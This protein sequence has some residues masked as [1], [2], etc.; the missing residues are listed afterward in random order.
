MSLPPSIGAQGAPH[1]LD[2]RYLL[3]GM[4]G[5]GGVGTVYQATQTSV[6][7]PVAVK[8]LNAG[9]SHD[10]E[11][12]ARFDLEAKALA[13]LSHPGCVTLFDFGHDQD[14]DAYYMVMEYIKGY[15]FSAAKRFG[16]SAQD[17]LKVLSDVCH[18]LKHAHAHGITHR[19]LKPSNIMIP[20]DKSQSAKVLD[21]GLARLYQETLHG[22][23]LSISGRIY[24]TPA[25]MSPEQCR[26]DLD[27][28]PAADIYALG[29]MLYEVIEGRL[30]F[31]ASSVTAILLMHIQN[32]VQ[33]PQNTRFSYELR[34]L[35]VQ[36]ALKDPTQRFVDLDAIVAMLERERGLLAGA[37]FPHPY[38]LDPLATPPP[39][40]SAHTIPNFPQP[41]TPPPFDLAQTLD[42]TPVETPDA[43][44][45]PRRAR[46]R[47]VGL[48]AAALCATGLLAS[49]AFTTST[50]ATPEALSKEVLV[51]RV[52]EP[53]PFRT[54]AEAQLVHTVPVEPVQATP[55]LLKDEEEQEATARMAKK[56]SD[57]A[58][59]T[60]KMEAPP[61]QKPAPKRLK[62]RARTLSL[63][64]ST[65]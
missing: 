48:A 35:C 64:P 62:P 41:P 16:M 3:H 28:C 4:I 5:S 54:N 46:F 33:L 38:P 51:P 52:L 45:P 40:Q 9:L 31:E 58:S 60:P 19:D 57:E 2:G 30:P 26:G 49:L 47:W 7:R 42:P 59:E 23:R 43:P 20:T 65:K 8:L 61:R 37:S 44:T 29:T 24:G 17:E 14:L 34:Q 55:E 12:L 36:M 22:E 39:I 53:A 27:I 32:E 63:H 21:F 25:Y 1:L 13:R 56:E 10:D 6:S 15:D 50:E 11:S 18:A